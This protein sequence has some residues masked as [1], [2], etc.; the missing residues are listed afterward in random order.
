MIY[1]LLPCMPYTIKEEKGISRSS[2]R[3]NAKFEI[4]LLIS[5][6]LETL[7]KKLRSC[8]DSRWYVIVGK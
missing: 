3:L 2:R 4:I 7:K 8:I 5:V 1:I 6:L